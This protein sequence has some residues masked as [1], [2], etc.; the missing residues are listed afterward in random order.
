MSHPGIEVIPVLSMISVC[1]SKETHKGI[2]V[3]S[4]CLIKEFRVPYIQECDF[5]VWCAG[6]EAIPVLS[7]PDDFSYKS[8]FLRV[9]LSS[10]CGTY[11][12]AKGDLCVWCAGIE[13]IP[14]LSKPDAAWKG[15]TGLPP[16][17]PCTIPTN[18]RTTTQQK[19]EA[20]PRRA[21]I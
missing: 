19:C 12:T 16:P 13:V 17:T 7:K 21:R 6:I 15:K 11:K 20:A 8:S 9:P 5:C 4:V 1:L 3:I 14:V 10:E 2:S 18:L